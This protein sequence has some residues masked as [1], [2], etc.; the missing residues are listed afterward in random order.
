MTIVDGFMSDLIQDLRRDE[1]V[2]SHPYRDTEGILTI[3]VGRNLEDRGLS[4]DEIDILL[5]NDL[6]WVV[7]DLDRNAPWWRDLDN[8][9]QRALANM[10]FNLGYPRLAGFKKMLAAL[11]AEDWDEAA[12]QALDSRWAVQV[13]DRAD[14]VA[15]LIRNG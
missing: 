2:R 8:A 13:G 6:K 5:M 9:R 1:G 4:D 11:Q 14:R 3:G 7:V 12:D 15:E 10:A